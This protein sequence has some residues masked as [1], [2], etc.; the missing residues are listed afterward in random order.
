MSIEREAR[1]LGIRDPVELSRVIEDV[2]QDSPDRIAWVRVIDS[3]GRTLVQN[4][5][6]VGQAFDPARLRQAPDE[7]IPVSDCSPNGRR[8]SAG[9]RVSLTAFSAAS[10]G[11]RSAGTR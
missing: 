9:H 5:K 2:R 8:Q 3:A 10:S 11:G 4:G 6:P 7:P 1:R